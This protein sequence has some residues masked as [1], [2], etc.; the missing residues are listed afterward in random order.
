M[1]TVL[2]TLNQLS[3]ENMFRKI[4][5]NRI[6][7]NWNSS[8]LREMMFANDCAKCYFFAPK[9]IATKGNVFAFFRKNCAKVLHRSVPEE[10]DFIWLGRKCFEWIWLRRIWLGSV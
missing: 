1:H 4:V 10:L 7:Q 8:I 5:Q 2:Y 9:C 6:T 3:N